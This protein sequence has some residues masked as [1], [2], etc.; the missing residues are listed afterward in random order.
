MGV[1][2]YSWIGLVKTFSVNYSEENYNCPVYFI[3]PFEDQK[4]FKPNPF[5]FA[6]STMNVD[7]TGNWQRTFSI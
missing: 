1:K 5:E 6:A 4:R 7:S 3:Q 2:W